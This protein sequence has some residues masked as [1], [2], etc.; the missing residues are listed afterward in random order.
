MSQVA[1]N[2]IKI[3]RASAYSSADFVEAFGG[4]LALDGT[5]TAEDKDHMI[6]VMANTIMELTSRGQFKLKDFGESMRSIAVWHNVSNTH[7]LCAI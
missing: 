5:V 2:C 7:C 3:G 4:Y 1:K 6:L